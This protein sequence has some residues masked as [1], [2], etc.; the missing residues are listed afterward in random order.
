MRTVASVQLDRSRIVCTTLYVERLAVVVRF[1]IFCLLLLVGIRIDDANGDRVID[2]LQVNTFLRPFPNATKVKKDLIPAV[3]LYLH[4]PFL[5][6]QCAIFAFSI[7]QE[8]TSQK[9]GVGGRSFVP[10]LL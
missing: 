8:C 1:S 2:P 5:L 10:A 9:F 3:D 7:C 4:S 6:C